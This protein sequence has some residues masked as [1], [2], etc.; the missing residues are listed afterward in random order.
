[1]V[2]IP[3]V[4]DRGVKVCQT[5]DHRARRIDKHDSR[6]REMKKGKASVSYATTLENSLYSLM[7]VFAVGW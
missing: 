2:V 5:A 7:V 4:I 1:M 3:E 6:P